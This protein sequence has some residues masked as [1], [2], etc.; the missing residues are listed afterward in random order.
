VGARRRARGSRFF[1]LH[2]FSDDDDNEKNRGQTNML[3][4]SGRGRA[5]ALGAMP[6][7]TRSRD[8]TPKKADAPPNVRVTSPERSSKRRLSPGPAPRGDLA[9]DAS[10]CPPA[11][12]FALSSS[13]WLFVY[14]VGVVK[15]LAERGYHKCV[16]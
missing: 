2:F 16:A 15:A 5:L 6:P 10:P 9:S 3:T 7:Q 11:R 13:G 4:R 14:Y 8:A 12:S 1:A